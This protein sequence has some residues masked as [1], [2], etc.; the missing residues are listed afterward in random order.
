[1]CT[2]CSLGYL[3]STDHGIS[4]T[5]SRGKARHT[6]VL[7]EAP[8]HESMML[9]YAAERGQSTETAFA[10]PTEKRLKRCR[11]STFPPWLLFDFSAPLKKENTQETSYNG[12]L[13]GK[14]RSPE[15]QCVS[16]T[17]ERSTDGSTSSASKPRVAANARASAFRQA[18]A[19][20]SRVSRAGGMNVDE[21]RGFLPT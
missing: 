2:Q 13:H 12:G 3:D 1:M 20:P 11:K 15:T 7:L 21:R 4:V 17:C 6:S 18:R 9:G 8:S 10:K 14:T 16:R 19:T 5:E